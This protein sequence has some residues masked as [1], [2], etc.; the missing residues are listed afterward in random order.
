MDNF[1]VVAVILSVLFTLS[2]PSASRPDP[3]TPDR[4]NLRWGPRVHREKAAIFT[5]EQMLCA[6]LESRVIHTMI[7][8]LMFG[9]GA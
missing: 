9:G 2:P 7:G 1:T 3:P 6:D 5:A 8:Q 4:N